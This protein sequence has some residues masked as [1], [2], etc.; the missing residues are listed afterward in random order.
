MAIESSILDAETGNTA[1]VDNDKELIVTS[2]GYPPTGEQKVLPFR[3][4]LTSDGTEGGSSDMR[5]DGS[6]TPQDFYI[7][8][9]SAQDLY[10][11]YLS[12]VIAD[13]GAVLNEFGSLSALSNGGTIF[14]ERS[15][16]TVTIADELQTNFD[17]VRACLG[18][19]SF[20]DGAAAFRANNVSGNS[21]AY[22]PVLDLTKI[23]PPYGI[24]LDAATTQRLVHRVNDN[25]SNLDQFDC[26]AYGFCR[27]S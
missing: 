19:P 20:G 1:E 12:F 22:I 21:E 2:R 16:Q 26:I 3:Q 13:A 11:T 15:D 6:S 17:Y 7:G 5:V 27:L 10:I 9:H 23:L 14:Y 25:V 8:S 4:Y 18:N 24:K